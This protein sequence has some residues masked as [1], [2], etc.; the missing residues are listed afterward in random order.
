[1]DHIYVNISQSI[2]PARA[3][4]IFSIILTEFILANKSQMMRG[5]LCYISIMDE[6]VQSFL[7]LSQWK[8]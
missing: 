1:M 3:C 5:L 2:P 6:S 4:S 8:Q 7:D